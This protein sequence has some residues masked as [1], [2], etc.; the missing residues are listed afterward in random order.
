MR[1]TWGVSVRR[2]GIYNL[3]HNNF[4]ENMWCQEELNNRK[5]RGVLCLSNAAIMICIGGRRASFCSMP[6]SRFAERMGMDNHI[7][8]AF[9]CFFPMS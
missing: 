5:A 6:T 4:K 3:L 1:R 2:D 9:L 7:F 8:P